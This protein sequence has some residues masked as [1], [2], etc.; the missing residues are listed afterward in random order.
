MQA[1]RWTGGEGAFRFGV[2][3]VE[4][5]EATVE[6]EVE[7]FSADFDAADFVKAKVA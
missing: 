7:W 5:R 6:E 1:I 2:V 3:E 4:F